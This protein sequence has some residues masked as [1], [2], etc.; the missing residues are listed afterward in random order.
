MLGDQAARQVVIAVL[1]LVGLSLVQS[2]GQSL[3]LA[4]LGLGQSLCGPLQL[5][6]MWNL[7]TA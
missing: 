3:A 2:G 4:A 1:T 5:F 7:C 6:G